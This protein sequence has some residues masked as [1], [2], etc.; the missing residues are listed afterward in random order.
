MAVPLDGSAASD[1]S[2]IRSIVAGSHF[3]ASPRFSPDGSHLAWIAWE[4]PQMPW[5]GT[6]LRVGAVD[7]A[8]TVTDWRVLAG[9]TTESIL[10]PTWVSDDELIAIADPVGWWNLER[11]RLDGTRTVIR[12]EDAEY[13]GPMWMLGAGWYSTLD[14][15]RLLAVRTLGTD[16]LVVIDPA[17]GGERARRDPAHGHRPRSAQRRPRSALGRVVD[18]RLGAARARPDLR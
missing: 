11:I 6:E 1:A 9:S 13:G 7:P 3:V 8:G 17:N 16:S 5:D 2:A 15:G 4:H 14:D 18:A 12:R 10:Q